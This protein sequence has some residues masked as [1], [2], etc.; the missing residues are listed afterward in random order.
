MMHHR[1]IVP[2]LLLSCLHH[3]PPDRPHLPPQLVRRLRCAMAVAHRAED[4]RPAPAA[5]SQEAVE[6]R[7]DPEALEVP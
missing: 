5:S 7:A 3:P 2:P 1:L 4:E 6:R